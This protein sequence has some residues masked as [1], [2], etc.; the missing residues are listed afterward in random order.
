LLIVL[1]CHIIAFI[2]DT[3]EDVSGHNIFSNWG[4]NTR[5]GLALAP[6]PKEIQDTLDLQ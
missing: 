1:L 5:G 2:A 6:N 3:V 4:I